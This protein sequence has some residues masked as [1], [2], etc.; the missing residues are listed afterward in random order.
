LEILGNVERELGIDQRIARV[1]VEHHQQRVA[2]RRGPGDLGRTDR[3][4][5]A[6]PVVDEHRLPQRRLQ[7]RLQLARHRVHDAAGRERDDHAHGLARPGL[8]G[9]QRARGAEQDGA[10][11]KDADEGSSHSI[12]SSVVVFS[13]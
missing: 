1:A 5:R 12:H 7:A 6:A 10:G 8:L 13:A 3:A 4:A 9:V 11:G 2:V